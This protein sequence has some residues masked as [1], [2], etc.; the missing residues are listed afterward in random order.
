MGYILKKEYRCQNWEQG[1]KGNDREMTWDFVTRAWGGR[2]KGEGSVE[3]QID[4]GCKN[5]EQ[6]STIKKHILPDFKLAAKTC[7]FGLTWVLHWQLKTVFRCDGSQQWKPLKR[8][9]LMLVPSVTLELES[10]TSL[11]EEPRTTLEFSHW[12]ICLHFK[13]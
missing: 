1:G 7:C 2:N 10:S 11:K 4:A 3:S 13:Q 12:R 9:E 6:V 8:F 5:N